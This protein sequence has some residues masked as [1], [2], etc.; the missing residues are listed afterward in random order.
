M[1]TSCSH[2]KYLK[3]LISKDVLIKFKTTLASQSQWS[4]DAKFA[5]LYEIWSQ[6]HEESSNTIIDIDATDTYEFSFP[7]FNFINDGKC[8]KLCK[9]I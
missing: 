1:H 9:K 8:G 5:G 2:L 6:M 7:E 4:G 3:S